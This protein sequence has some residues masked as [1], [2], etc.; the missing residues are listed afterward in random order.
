MRNNLVSPSRG[1]TLLELLIAIAIFAIAGVAIM[2]ATSNHNRTLGMITDLTWAGMVA[3]NELQLAK[4]EEKWPP[5]LRREGESEM[6]NGRVTEQTF[7]IGL[8]QRHQVTED[9]GDKGDQTQY[10]AD[11]FALTYRCVQEQTHHDAKDSNL[12][13]RCQEGRNRRWRPLINVRRPQVERHQRQFK[14]KANN[15]Q[16]QTG[17]S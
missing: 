14:T 1:F 11:G 5:E 9:D 7:N 8:A 17:L 4:L 13:C 15:H 6:G 12:A 3:E 10:D 16:P 2:Q